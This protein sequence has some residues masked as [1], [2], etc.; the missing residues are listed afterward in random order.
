MNLLMLEDGPIQDVFE[1]GLKVAIEERQLQDPLVFLQ[2]HIAVLFEDDA[3][4]GQ[5]AGLV[6]AQHVHRAEVLDR[7]EALDDH[8][9]ARHQHRALGQAHAHD[10]RKHL[11]REPN[12]DRE[13]EQKR[14][15]PSVLAETVDQEHQRHHHRH[16]LEH[17]PGESGSR[18]GRSWSAAGLA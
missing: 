13:R 7:V 2:R 10:H 12:R 6:G 16:E 15:A 14:F 8:L 3:V 4:H 11:R 18:R 5:R 17:Q 1:P 9:L